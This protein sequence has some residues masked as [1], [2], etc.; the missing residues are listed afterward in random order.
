MYINDDILIIITGGFSHIGACILQN[1]TEHQSINFS[2]HK[3]QIALKIIANKLQ[4]LHA[5]I[6]IL[7]G[8]HIENIS[9]KQISNVLN[10]CEILGEKIKNLL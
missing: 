6:C 2:S 9:K 3:D 10:L 4:H 7:G 5:N 8:I 1:H